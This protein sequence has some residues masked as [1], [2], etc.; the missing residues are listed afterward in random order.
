MPSKVWHEITYPF[1]NFNGAIFLIDVCKIAQF[2]VAMEIVMN[3]NATK[4]NRLVYQPQYW[5][6]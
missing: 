1:L 3:E 4:K 2:S 6:V 5:H